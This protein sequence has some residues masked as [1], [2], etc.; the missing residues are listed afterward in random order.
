M[1]D[2]IHYLEPVVSSLLEKIA[3]LSDKNYQLKIWINREGPQ[4]NSFDETVNFFYDLSE[5]VCEKYKTLNLSENQL[6]LL[7]NFQKVLDPFIEMEEEFSKEI[8]NS[9]DSGALTK[10]AKEVLKAFPLY[11]SRR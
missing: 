7:K 9:C 6:T 3:Y 8:L 4:V 10:Q 2:P 1:K 5:I 11:R